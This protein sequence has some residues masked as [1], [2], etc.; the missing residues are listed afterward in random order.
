MYCDDGSPHARAEARRG[1][2]GLSNKMRDLYACG[3]DAGRDL[4]ACG[5]DAGR[6]CG[7]DAGRIGV[8]AYIMRT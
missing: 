8:D 5:V 3:V 6:G 7:L 1:K 4:W 2:V